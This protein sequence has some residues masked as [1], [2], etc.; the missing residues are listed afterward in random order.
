MPQEVVGNLLF[1]LG[2][3]LGALWT[4]ANQRDIP[5]QNI[6]HLGHFVEMRLAQ[7]AP[8][9]RDAAVAL[10]R[11]LRSGCFR[12][13]FHGSQLVNG[14]ERATF[15]DPL[16]AVQCWRAVFDEDCE[17]CKQQKR[18][19][20]EEHG[21]RK[22]A[23]EQPPEEARGAVALFGQYRNSALLRHMRERY[24]CKQLFIGSK[25]R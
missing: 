25:E 10:L 11:P 6:E 17:H 4:R 21:E 20:H 18:R 15:A 22:Q 7:Y 16:L 9:A 14:K 3:E 13:F 23:F 24:F 5:A 8:D 12:I 19:C 2:D 1:K